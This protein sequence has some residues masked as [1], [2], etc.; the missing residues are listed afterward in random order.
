MWENILKKDSDLT[1]EQKKTLEEMTRQLTEA[2]NK[3]D[4]KELNLMFGK[5]S[6]FSS[7]EDFMAMM[8]QRITAAMKGGLLK[9][10]ESGFNDVLYYKGIQPARDA[11]EVNNI[12]DTYTLLDEEDRHGL[13]QKQMNQFQ[14][15]ASLADDL[16]D[17]LMLLEEMD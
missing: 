14:R 10:S 15:I 11:E 1:N 7:K 9:K 4:L 13:N 3:F 2:A 17:A 8:V 16:S 12:R 6:N 5:N